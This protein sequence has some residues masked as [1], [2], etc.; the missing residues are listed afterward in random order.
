MTYKLVQTEP[1]WI[2][3]GDPMPK[4]ENYPVLN[5]QEAAKV[6]Q[7]TFQNDCA[8]EICQSQLIVDSQ[9]LLQSGQLNR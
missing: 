9:L 4:I 2:R 7:A 6:F 1:P 8:N 5:Q 3:S